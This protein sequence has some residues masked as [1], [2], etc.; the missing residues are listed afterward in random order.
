[1][2]LKGACRWSASS[3]I[4]NIGPS[5]VSVKGAWR[6]LKTCQDT[7][8]TLWF[9]DIQ[10]HSIHIK[11]S[12]PIWWN[13]S[14]KWFFS[15]SI[16]KKY[17]EVIISID[18]LKNISHSQPLWSKK[19]M[20]WAEVMPTCLSMFCS[21]SSFCLSLSGFDTEI[22]SGSVDPVFSWDATK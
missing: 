8:I 4:L 20:K 12:E 18:W 19:N 14:R 2:C 17:F 10:F 3:S 11:T 6:I 21:R 1:M 13:T 9:P 7:Q 15:Y 16:T 22:S 5:P